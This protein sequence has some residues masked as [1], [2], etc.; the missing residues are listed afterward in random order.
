VCCVCAVASWSPEKL[1][2]FDR[3]IGMAFREPKPTCAEM[4]MAVDE[5]FEH[6][7]EVGT[8]PGEIHNRVTPEQLDLKP[9]DIAAYERD[10]GTATTHLVKW[11]PSKL[12]DG[13]WVAWL[14]GVSGCVALCRCTPS[15]AREEG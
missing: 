10:D 13:T 5:A 6:L 3:L 4:G 15:V 1:A 8:M 11:P 2:A 9:G 14:V 12:G 7:G